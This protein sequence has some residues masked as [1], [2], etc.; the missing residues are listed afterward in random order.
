MAEIYLHH[1]KDKRLYASVYRWGP[2][3]EAAIITGQKHS[4]TILSNF[5]LSKVDIVNAKIQLAELL[6]MLL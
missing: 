4:I 2:T 6:N 5:V 1:R 3:R